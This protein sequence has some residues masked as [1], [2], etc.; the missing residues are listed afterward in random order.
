[1]CIRDR[2]CTLLVNLIN[3]SVNAIFIYGFNMGAAGAGI[4]TL[5]SRIAAA[6]VILALLGRAELG[7][8]LKDFRHFRFHGR[9][10][11]SILLIGIPNG[12]ESGM[13]QI[14]KLLVLNLSLIHI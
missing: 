13:F 6:V 11:K 2:Y 7:L 4:G 12:L 1:M 5:V 8:H 9:M 14:G 10:L 3:I